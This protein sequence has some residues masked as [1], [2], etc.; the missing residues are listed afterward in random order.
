MVEL[1][2]FDSK[3]IQRRN[4]MLLQQNQGINN[5]NILRGFFQTF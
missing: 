5:V 4:K 3:I 2:E 1:K